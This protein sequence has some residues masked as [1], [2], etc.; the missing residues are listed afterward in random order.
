MSAPGLNHVGTLILKITIITKRMIF[1]NGLGRTLLCA[2]MALISAS[3]FAE[4]GTMTA[5]TTDNKS[6]TVNLADGMQSVCWAETAANKPLMVSVFTGETTYDNNGRL[7][8]VAGKGEIH[9]EMEIANLK[10]IS[11]SGL[12]S[13]GVI[14]AD[15]DVTVDIVSGKVR[16]SGVTEALDFSIYRLDGTETGRMRITSDMEID[17][18]QYGTGVHL[19]RIGKRT[20]K[21]MTR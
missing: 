16:V 7:T 9:F 6:V 18:K 21:I 4:K 2:L 13:V 11:F 20:F 19:V 8:A 5:V 1:M 10:S 14:A 15:G 3:A 17:L 12:T